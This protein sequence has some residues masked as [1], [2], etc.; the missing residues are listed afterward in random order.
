MKFISEETIMKTQMPRNIWK[1]N[2]LLYND[3]GKVKT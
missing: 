3:T 2:Y 1:Q